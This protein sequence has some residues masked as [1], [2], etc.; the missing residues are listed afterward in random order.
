[1][2]LIGLQQVS[3]TIEKEVFKYMEQVLILLLLYLIILFCWLTS[4]EPEVRI[5]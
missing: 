4:T 1:M 3:A 5:A 2:C